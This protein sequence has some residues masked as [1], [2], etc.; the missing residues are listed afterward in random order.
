VL[1][2]G[3]T[4]TVPPDLQYGLLEFIAHMNSEDYDALP[5]DFV[6][7]GIFYPDLINEFS[8]THIYC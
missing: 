4:I 8:L 5:E 6:K 7:I 1:D 2:W 3:M